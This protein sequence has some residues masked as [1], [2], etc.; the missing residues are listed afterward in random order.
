MEVIQDMKLNCFSVLFL[1]LLKY[2]R[3]N[4]FSNKCPLQKYI[5]NISKKILYILLPI[6]KNAIA[7]YN[8]GK[9]A[10]FTLCLRKRIP[11]SFTK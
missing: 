1:L 4:I 6:I 10:L 8:L 3:N 9:K 5:I 7:A 11:A 2:F